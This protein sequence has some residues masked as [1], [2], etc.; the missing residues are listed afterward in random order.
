MSNLYEV[1]KIKPNASE[2]EIKKAYYELSK[3]YHPDRCKDDNACQK[4]QEINSAY[5]ILM[6]DKIR[7]NYI[8]M[9]QEEKSNFQS[10]LEKIFTNNFKLTELKNMGFSFT[11]K[12]WDYLETNYM[13]LI[14]SLNF[15]E[16]FELITKGK[17]P[18]KKP[19]TSTNLCS[20][21]EV[22][23]WDEFQAEY[24][25]DLPFNYQK[26]NKL[27]IRLSLNLTL[28]DLIEESKRK[29][30]IKRTFEDETVTTTYIFNLKKPFV[31][32]TGGGD[33][34][35]GDYGNIIIQLNLP[36]NFY[37][38]E[39]LILYEY[40]I[41]LYQMVYG[42]DISLALGEDTLNIEYKNYVPSRDGLLVNIDKLN[43][44]NHYFG[45]KL[46]LNYEHSDEKED[47]LKL[48]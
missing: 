32:F 40:Q 28:N 3:K 5:T 8:Q 23:C 33:M 41:S 15:K 20:D 42:L 4:F 22:N 6:D 10:I 2:Q 35:D 25:Y 30:K 34:E 29:I 31:V 47:I 45:I 46:V 11:K 39:N 27:D 18:E 16:L 24:Y 9:N 17:I 21:S 7:R 13:K 48:L 14:N 43:I 26:I 19:S 37:W 38:K 36:K 1:L 44:K 12:D